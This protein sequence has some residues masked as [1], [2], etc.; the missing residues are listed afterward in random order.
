MM[1]LSPPIFVALDIDEKDKAIQMA[2]DVSEFVGGFKVGPRLAFRYGK[3]L[4]DEL[5]KLGTVF[6]DLK[7]YDIPNTMLSSIQTAFE[8]GVDFV[9]IHA[10]CGPEALKAVA[11]LEAKLN[12]ARPFKILAV[13]ILTSYN[14]N[15][16][17]VNYKKQSINEHVLQLA[18][19]AYE[20]GIRGFVC[21]S[22]EVAA[23]KEKFND[24]YF[25]TP[26]IRLSSD[27]SGDQK[28]VVEP[29]DAIA[30]GASAMV[31]GRPICNA[32]NPAEAAKTYRDSLK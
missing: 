11:E 28:R 27:A 21:S 13:T 8:L 23:L 20:A 3:P 30:R 5:T 17:P 9:T 16:L 10:T 24:G 4:F 19:Q 22:F 26:G 7:F 25:V 14:E 31:V 6:L 12:E 29:K 18:T 2:K 15:N 1:T 32:K